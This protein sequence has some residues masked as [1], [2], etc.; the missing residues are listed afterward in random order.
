MRVFRKPPVD[1]ETPPFPIPPPLGA[2]EELLAPPAAGAT[3]LDLQL[4]DSSAPVGNAHSSPHPGGTQATRRPEPPKPPPLAPLVPG[5]DLYD[6]RGIQCHLVRTETVPSG[7]PAT[8]AGRSRLFPSVFDEATIKFEMIEEASATHPT[9]TARIRLRPGP[10]LP[11][12]EFITSFLLHIRQQAAD[13]AVDPIPGAAAPAGVSQ[14]PPP[15]N[16]AAD[17]GAV[18]ASPVTATRKRKGRGKHSDV[19]KDERK[20]QRR[21]A[22]LL[23][24]QDNTE[25]G[26]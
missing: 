6:R 4:T 9:T 3:V 2:P 25:A 16:S 19:A 15:A 7:D 13:G 8:R 14:L 24:L 1:G 12:P 22:F 21:A 11:L 18:A 20:R 17:D 10:L 26:T 5:A 23:T